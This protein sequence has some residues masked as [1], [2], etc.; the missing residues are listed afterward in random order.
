MP[1]FQDRQFVDFDSRSWCGL[2]GARVTLLALRVVPSNSSPISDQGFGGPSAVESG[3]VSFL[4][5]VGANK[6]RSH[7]IFEL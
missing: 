7:V 3:F 6:M 2:I 5:R 4:G 1:E